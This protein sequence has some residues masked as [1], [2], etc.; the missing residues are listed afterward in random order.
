M[1]FAS[2]VEDHE[3]SFRHVDTAVL[4]V[5]GERLSEFSGAVGE[6]VI[7][8]G[9]EAALPHDV[10]AFDWFE[11]ADQH[12]AG[13]AV[14]FGDD[15]HAVVHAVREIDVSVTAGSEDDARAIGDAGG[16]VGGEIVTAE[17][18]FGFDDDAGG[19]SVDEHFAEEVAGDVDG[20]PFVE[21]AGED[22]A[23]HDFRRA[24]AMALQWES[25][26]QIL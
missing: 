13:S 14:V 24:K 26:A 6:V 9:F 21:T 22:S 12:A 23:S 17:V 8:V 10:E 5:N 25:T 2:P 4:P 7:A 15:V 16:G 11:G 20:G 3:I 19:G 18:G 1:E